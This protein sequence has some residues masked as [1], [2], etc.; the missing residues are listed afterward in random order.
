MLLYFLAFLAAVYVF[1]LVTWHA[2][3]RYFV[4]HYSG[5]PDMEH[6]RSPRKDGKIKG[7]A[8]VCGGSIAG[9]L[10]AQICAAHFERVLIVEP[11]AW[12]ATD[13]G[14]GLHGWEQT[15]SR[16]AAG[17][18]KTTFAGTH[19]KL[20][21]AYFPKG[22]P[23]T[24]F[25][26]RQGLE[27]LIRRLVLGRPSNIE[28]IVGLVTGLVRDPNDIFRVSQV[29]IRTDSGTINLEA[30]LVVDCT[31]VTRAG[32]KWLDRLGFGQSSDN[33]IPLKDLKIS[34]D[35]KLHYTS[36]MVKLTPELTGRLPIPGGLE[37]PQAVYTYLE[38]QPSLGRRF[39]AIT[40]PDGNQ[41]LLFGGQSSDVPPGLR[42][43]DDM[44]R[45]AESMVPFR[46][47]MP[48]WVF[49]TLEMLKEAEDTVSVSQVRVPGTAY[50]RYHLASGLPSNFIALGDSVM[51][52][53]PTF[54]VLN[55]ILRCVKASSPL[56]SDFSKKFF[57]EQFKKIDT[58]GCKS[59]RLP[60]FNAALGLG[61]P[62]DPFHPALALKICGIWSEIQSIVLYFHRARNRFG[63]NLGFPHVGFGVDPSLIRHFFVP[64]APVMSDCVARRSRTCGPVWCRFNSMSR[65]LES[66]AVKNA[67]PPARFQGYVFSW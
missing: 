3:S 31:G 19:V 55:N 20:P 22:L 24:L 26:S 18:F 30:A 4:A 29:I 52:V 23:N 48:G 1:F 28:Q 49:E 41:I 10:T 7:N 6:L 34:F 45:Y 5:T 15:H 67:V 43:V 9:L 8:V 38:D 17:D 14:R 16:V 65:S 36:M 53:N 62:L 21:W 37:E 47:P 2:I 25:A 42:S 56:S 27:T 12:L 44:I 54:S 51:S 32:I 35:Q 57:S 64:A 40:K 58:T 60:L 13:A 50:I 63:D 46:D 11:E 39:F 66:L 59:L 61:T 33:G